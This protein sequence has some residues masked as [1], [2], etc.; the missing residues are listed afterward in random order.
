METKITY[1]DG[2]RFQV[3][4]RDHEIIS[5][6]L[7]ENGGT[8]RGMTPPELLLASLGTCVGY[9]G[10]EYLRTR[11]LSA[12]GLS[13]TVS[14]QKTQKPARLTDLRIGLSVPGLDGLRHRDGVLRAAKNCL[15]HNTLTH[16]PTIDI[17][18]ESKAAEPGPASAG[19]GREALN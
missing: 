19:T 4:A 7:P 11:N 10:A 1:L 2:V 14:A 18:L 3:V 6:Q 17:D 9:Y 5:D 16:A 15:I 8:D 12:A 13:V